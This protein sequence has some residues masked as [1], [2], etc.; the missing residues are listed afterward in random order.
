MFSPSKNIFIRIFPRERKTDM[1]KGLS[2]S[3]QAG[4]ARKR[5]KSVTLQKASKYFSFFSLSQKFVMRQPRSK[6][7]P[8]T[9]A[10]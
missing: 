7:E 3:V 5:K 8:R 10:I 1:E 4:N 6:R 9:A 2:R